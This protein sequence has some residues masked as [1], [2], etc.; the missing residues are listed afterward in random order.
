MYWVHFALWGVLGWLIHRLG[1]FGV[2]LKIVVLGASENLPWSVSWLKRDLRYT[3]P[4]TTGTPWPQGPFPGS[5]PDPPTHS[6][7]YNQMLHQYLPIFFETER[8]AQRQTTLQKDIKDISHAGSVNLFKSF[9]TQCSSVRGG[10][11]FCGPQPMPMYEKE[12]A[13]QISS[14]RW[15]GVVSRRASF[16]IVLAGWS[17]QVFWIW[18]WADCC[19]IKPSRDALDIFQHVG[20]ETGTCLNW[21]ISFG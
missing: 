18:V 8:N 21:R 5:L 20:T 9:F 4:W 19:P 6:T 12:D 14:E 16:D 11:L 2:L 10:V 7:R 17:L 3:R 1:W 15:P 13:R